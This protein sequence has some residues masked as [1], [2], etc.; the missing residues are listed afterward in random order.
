MQY[1]RLLCVGLF[2]YLFIQPRLHLWKWK[3][4]FGYF[5]TALYHWA[6]ITFSVLRP[7]RMKAAILPFFLNLQRM[8]RWR[9]MVWT[10]FPSWEI[11]VDKDT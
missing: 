1:I 7:R 8:T 4:A 5:P 6:E 11:A 9:T 10:L 3:F 2:F